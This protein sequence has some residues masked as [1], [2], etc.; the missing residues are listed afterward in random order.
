MMRNPLVVVAV[1]ILTVFAAGAKWPDSAAAATVTAKWGAQIEVGGVRP[2]GSAT[3]SFYA[4][5]TGA[6]GLRLTGLQP[7]TSY[8]VGLYTGSC[9]RLGA[10]VLAFP[11]V[12]SSISGTVTRGLTFR[13]SVAARLRTLVRGKLSVAIG[14]LRRCGTL[15]RLS[16]SPAPTPTPTPKPTF[17]ASPL[18]TPTPTPTPA[19]TPLPTPYIY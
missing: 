19:P 18:P 1:A 6:L 2:Q 10:R 9:S 13:S 7:A 12:T 3:L 17:S 8:W 16:L 5:G 15:V 11:T 14:S 4:T